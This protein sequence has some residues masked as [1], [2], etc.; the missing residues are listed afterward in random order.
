MC[1]AAVSSYGAALE[2]VPKDLRDYEMCLAAVSRSARAI[3]EVPEYL[4]EY[5]E[6]AALANQ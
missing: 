4:P 5:D 2:Y 1:L 3:Y 6:L